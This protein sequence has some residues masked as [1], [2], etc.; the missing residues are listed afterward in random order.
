M[1]IQRALEEKGC[2]SCSTDQFRALEGSC[3]SHWRWVCLEALCFSWDFFLRKELR[4]SPSFSQR[5]CNDWTPQ[6]WQLDGI[7]KCR[8]S[9]S[10]FSLQN[11]GKILKFRYLGVS[12]WYV[13]KHKYPAC[14]Q[15]K[16]FLYKRPK[17]VH[18]LGTFHVQRGCM[19]NYA[20]FSSGHIWKQI[21]NF[22]T[23]F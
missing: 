8:Y 19:Q 23:I 21:L 2:W 14:T 5:H 9:I 3:G 16:G 12:W 6:L 17:Y 20:Y 4:Y 1:E 15:P 11:Q 7:A 22:I 10:S 18:M 13:Y